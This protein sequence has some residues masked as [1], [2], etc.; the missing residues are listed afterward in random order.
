MKKLLFC[1]AY[2]VMSLTHL[3]GQEQISKNIYFATDAFALDDQSA[4]ELQQ[5]IQQLDLYTEH[6][7]TI[8]GHTD[9][10]GTD[11]YNLALSE[12]RAASVAEYFETQGIP[13]DILDVTYEGETQLVNHS[14]VANLKKQNRRVS[15][16][17]QVYKYENVDEFISLLDSENTNTHKIN[18]N[19]EIQL[20]LNKG[21][22][23]TIPKNAFCLED[24]TPVDNNNVEITIKEAY[25]YLDMIDHQL[26]TQ[27]EDEIL[28]TG[29]MIYISATK[30][31]QK[32]QLQ[33]GKAIDLTYPIQDP[34]KGMELF[35]PTDQ[36]S[37]EDGEGVVWQ[38]TG[39]AIETVEVKKEEKFIQIDLSPII[40]YREEITNLKKPSLVFGDMPKFP[41]AI[42]K[43]YPPSTKIYDD[44]KY[45]E[46]YK[47]YEIALEEYK[48]D[49]K[50]YPE[51]LKKWTRE[52]NER[53]KDIATH[54]YNLNVYYT[55]R[56]LVYSIDRLV[57]RQATE[58]HDKL[59]ADVFGYLDK[60]MLPIPFN[61]KR[62]VKDAFQDVA[63]D[64]KENVGLKIFSS[65]NTVARGKIY[66][67]DFYYILDA[68][69]KEL[70]TG[71]FN[72]GAINSKRASRY[73]VSTSDLGWINCDRFYYVPEKN[74]TN[75]TL[76][77][78][79]KDEKCFLVF[80][81]IKSVLRPSG[82]KDKTFN[83]IPKGEAVTLLALKF[84]N[85]QAY[86]A[87]QDITTGSVKK[88]ELDY[89]ETTLSK[90][91]DIIKNIASE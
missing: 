8:V 29:G 62:H 63:R 55:Q 45:K 48:E 70:N 51:R 26:F 25:S 74:R 39:A 91:K 81:N 75:L 42:R 23:V 7:I 60:D 58:S 56:R 4:T 57:D 35:V 24:G 11:E 27:T 19:T 66:C 84:I 83:N 31:G 54:K 44:E 64:V 3:N 2:L 5:F 6:D 88:M 20:T 80:K 50:T 53:K 12:R 86:F 43:P 14:K 17:A 52:A 30:N 18:S 79:E 40:N 37:S 90:L 1:L 73:L 71:K 77:N 59:L 33:D 68:K 49:Q 87:K 65:S 78:V 34:L 72:M 76:A 85:D 38:T 22:E 82:M 32:L 46:V 16:L 69:I 61:E 41:R 67:Q 36:T 9:Q 89:K 13:S 21:T 47:K 28:E 15:I 10:D